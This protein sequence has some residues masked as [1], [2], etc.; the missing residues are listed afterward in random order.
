MQHSKGFIFILLI[1]I[2]LLSG[3]TQKRGSTG[4]LRGD[5]MFFMD[6]P[7]Q[8]GKQDTLAYAKEPFV[9][10]AFSPFTVQTIANR[11]AIPDPLWHDLAV[12]REEWCQHSP[13]KPSRAPKDTDYVF[14]FQ[15]GQVENPVY[16]VPPELLPPAIQALIALVPSTDERLIAP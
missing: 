11:A 1:I 4:Y 7:L 6:F 14:I 15:C 2:L 9:T 13:I 12:L 5:L 3:C 8:N 16:A 10:R